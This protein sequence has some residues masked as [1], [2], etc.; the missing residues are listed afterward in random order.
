MLLGRVYRIF[1]RYADRHVA[2]DVPGGVLRDNQGRR[3]LVLEPIQL[4]N[5][6]LW[7]TVSGD[8]D[9]PEVQLN[10]SRHRLSP[11]PGGAPDAPMVFAVDVP[12]DTGPVTL[13]ADVGDGLRGHR[14]AGVR[15]ARLSW[16]RRAMALRFFWQLIGLAPQI[17]RW[18]VKGDLGA[19]EV[20]KARLGLVPQVAAQPVSH[21][22]FNLQAPAPQAP[23]ATLVMPVF[24]AFDVLR[25]ALDRIDRHSGDHWRLVLVDDASTDLRILPFLEEWSTDPAR[26]H[27]VHVL[28]SARNEGFVGA[29]NRGLD[30]ATK[31]PDDPVVL[32]NSDA[33]VPARWLDRLLAPL[34]DTSVAS[35]TPMS[36]DAEIFSIPAICHRTDLA[37]GAVDI[38]DAAAARFDPGAAQVDVPTGVGFCMALAPGFLAQVAHF[39]PVFGLGYGE[40]NDWCLK[41]S[42]LGGR[43]VAV[44]N[45][46]VEHR[47]GTSFGSAAKQRLLEK[48]LGILARRYPT[49]ENQVHHFVQH[50][51]LVT[52]RLSLGMVW[53]GAHQ[54]VPVPVYLGHAMGGGADMDLSRRIA[55]DIA[56]DRSAVV[57]RVGQH[58]R[59]Q[60]ELHCPLGVVR[61]FTDHTDTM[62]AVL[63]HLPQRCIIYS[64]GVGDRDSVSLPDIL[65]RLAEGGTHPVEVLMHDYFPIS[66]S[67][68]LLG[69]AGGY[70]G[71]PLAG[72]AAEA[73]PAHQARGAD[74]RRAVGLSDWQAAWGRLMRAARSITVFSQASRSIVATAYPEAA[75]AVV[76][77]P[78]TLLQVPPRISARLDQAAGPVIGVLGNIGVQKGARVVQALAG[79]L[80]REGTGRVVVIGYMDPDFGL[81]APSQVHGAY[82]VRDLPGLVAR[83]GITCWLIPSIW[84]ETFS[85]TTH[86]ALATGMPVYAFD[87]GA[88]GEAVAAAVAQGA[89]G[90]VVPEDAM[91]GPDLAGV[92]LQDLRQGRSAQALI[93]KG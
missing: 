81:P 33:L 43:H 47:G 17:F 57:L 29:A 76:V 18:K 23:P 42:A 64:C 59:W 78:H 8:V 22:L 12:V 19:R 1:Q 53:A 36:N 75:A 91:N 37:D 26:A 6:R 45:L 27:R 38:L 56:Q 74:G 44:G 92:L 41:T 7:F 68:T 84:P 73:D 79:A 55:Q 90:A 61:G 24:N 66:P 21:A 34:A 86:E 77:A 51:P 70:G 40:E 35:V 67:Y 54:D 60:I 62:L 72:G 83:Y 11:C 46:F 71:V 58:H 89:P 10:R 13:H 69:T 52:A 85:F 14:F 30:H 93:T 87:L 39:D 32:V 88:Q 31:W 4:R 28:R 5:N 63:G 49:Y 2:F 16:S 50:D 80:Q 15:K 3:V 65:L 9:A 20:V 48:N 25:D 82:E